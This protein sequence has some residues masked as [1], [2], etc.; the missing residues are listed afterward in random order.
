MCFDSLKKILPQ[1]DQTGPEHKAKEKGS[2][3]GDVGRAKV[4][5][6]RLSCQL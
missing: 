1:L 4:I 6:I 2:H 5:N 3:S